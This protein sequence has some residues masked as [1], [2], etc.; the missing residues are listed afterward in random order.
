[1]VKLVNVKCNG[2]PINKASKKTKVCIKTKIKKAWKVTR[3]WYICKKKL[4][5]WEWIARWKNDKAMENENE[6]KVN[7]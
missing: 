1:M 6:S 2:E 7:S 4:I 3:L 5:V